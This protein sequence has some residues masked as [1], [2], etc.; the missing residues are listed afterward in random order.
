MAAK[1]DTVVLN[2]G[3]DEY[4]RCSL[5]GSEWLCYVYRSRCSACMDDLKAAVSR[6]LSCVQNNVLDIKELTLNF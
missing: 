4:A 6:T 2:S 1:A 5:Q 3:D